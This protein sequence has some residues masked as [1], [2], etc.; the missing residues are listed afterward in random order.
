MT[1]NRAEFGRTPEG[2]A[3][4]LL[5]LNSG[6]AS[7]GI[8]TFGAALRS[9][10]VPDRTGSPVDVVLGY[11]TLEEYRTNDAYLGAV[12]GRFANRIAG[13]RFTLN[14]TDYT[15]AVNN[16]PNHLHGGVVGWSY[17][18]W[19]V[20]E[21]TDTRAVLTLHS[22]DM[23]EGYPG[24][25]DVT[26][27]YRLEGSALT[28]TYEAVSDRDT[29]INL[30][31]HS[32]FNLAGHSSGFAMDQVVSLAAS[33]YT[34][35]DETSIPF[36]RLDSVEGTPMDLRTPR[37]FAAQIDDGFQQL[38]WG[39]GY[40]HNYVLDGAPGQL[41]PAARVSCPSTGITLTAETTLPGMQLYTANWLTDRKGKNGARYAPRHAFCL[42]TQFFPDSPNKPGF[43]S[44]IL[45][46][47]E[48]YCHKTRFTFRAE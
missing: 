9:L 19:E 6:S 33:R 20:A 10:T 41:H 43:P 31:N 14:G 7:C 13:G 24:N 34:P 47:G 46:A 37:P 38:V 4:E 12:V 1:A 18:V 27:T 2:R 32:Y 42:E 26:V 17:R 11:D 30:T 15:L 36:G 29:P 22:Q 3:V 28:L 25:V 5:T 35:A 40:D 48:T 16:G 39:R 45:K 44:C 23:E 21:L 8:I